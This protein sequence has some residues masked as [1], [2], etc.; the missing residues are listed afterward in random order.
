M[1]ITNQTARVV[2]GRRPPPSLKSHFLFIVLSLGLL[3]F[4]IACWRGFYLVAADSVVSSS[5]RYGEADSLRICADQRQ[6][7]SGTTSG[8]RMGWNE[9]DRHLSEK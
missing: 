4:F 6:G 9:T 5:A 2:Q 3:A 1:L 7:L 8:Q